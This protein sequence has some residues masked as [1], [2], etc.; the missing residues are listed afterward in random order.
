MNSQDQNIE[1]STQ[2]AEIR[3]AGRPKG[4]TSEESTKRKKRVKR[5]G[6]SFKKGR[7]SMIC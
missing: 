4:L 3:K 6:K 7:S 2:N 1:N 5:K